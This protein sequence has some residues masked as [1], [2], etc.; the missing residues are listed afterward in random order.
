MAQYAYSKNN[1]SERVKSAEES[2]FVM[3]QNIFEERTDCGHMQSHYTYLSFKIKN[4]DIAVIKKMNTFS[5]A[6]NNKTVASGKFFNLNS[7][8]LASAE[9]E[10]RV[11]GASYDFIGVKMN[12]S[13]SDGSGTNLKLFCEDKVCNFT[14][15]LHE[16]HFGFPTIQKKAKYI[17]S[18]YDRDILLKQIYMPKIPQVPPNHNDL[19]SPVDISIEKNKIS[20]QSSVPIKGASGAMRITWQDDSGKNEEVFLFKDSKAHM[21]VKNSINYNGNL[22]YA[23]ALLYYQLPNNTSYERKVVVKYKASSGLTCNGLFGK[24]E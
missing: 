20:A 21:P 18:F 14:I 19:Y 22:N 1:T 24:K 7:A 5:I 11:N 2:Y 13:Y 16:K 8:L 3:S 23:S 12:G 15:I 4:I 17:I 9:N 6:A 10:N